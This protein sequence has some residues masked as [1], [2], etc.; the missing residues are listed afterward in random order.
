MSKKALFVAIEGTD[1]SGKATQTK[2]LVASCRRAGLVSRIFEFPRH[3]YISAIMVELYLGGRHSVVD[4]TIPE[5]VA[6]YYALDRAMAK[7]S[8]LRALGECDIVIADRFT[9]S[10]LAH[11]ATKL[12][13]A[14]ARRR[15]YEWVLDLETIRYQIPQPD[16]SIVLSVDSMA[17]AE[18]LKRRQESGRRKDDPDYHEK[19]NDHQ[20]MAHRNYQEL[21]RI[22]PKKFIELICSKEG[23]MLSAAIVQQQLWQSIRK[24]LV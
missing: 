20:V 1:S 4:K 9:G 7:D 24:L 16:L 22:Y 15:F 3:E 11:Q 17:A 10:N 8:L 18:S 6:T 5:L 14:T 21:C 12:K 2:M 19:D 23:K 13:S